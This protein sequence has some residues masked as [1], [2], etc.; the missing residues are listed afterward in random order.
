MPN[1]QLC[2]AVT[3]RTMS[4]IRRNRDAATGADI[5][6][7]RLDTVDR[8]DVAGALEGRRCPVIV[9]C[10]AAW[11]NGFFQGAE[12]ERRRI[13]EEA[14]ALGAEFVDVEAKAG[15]AGEL[16]AARGGRGV[17]V[18]SHVYGE[19]PSDLA[20]RWE[21]LTGS[22]AEIAKLAVEARSLADTAKVMALGRPAKDDGRGYVLIAMGDQGLAS[23]VLS[24]RT[25]NRWTYAGD[26][27]APGQVSAQRMLD[28]FRFRDLRPGTAVYGVV[29]NPVM[30]SLSPVMHNAGF[31]HFG[32][33]AV[34]LPLLATDAADFVEFARAIGLSGA[35]ITAPFKVQLMEA[36][37]ELEPLAE[38]VGAINT[39]I[40]RDGKWKGANTDVYGFAAP[41]LAK[42]QN[43]PASAGRTNPASAGRLAAGLRTTI[44]GAGGA[45]RAVAVALADLGAAVT[46]CARRPEAAREV[47]ALAD[48]QIGGLP[49]PAGSWDVLI[50]STS[51]DGDMS[52]NSPVPPATLDGRLVYELLYVPPVTR[53]MA[54]AAAAGCITIGGLE[55]LVA[56]AEKQFE[57]W[58]GQTPPAGLFQ[59]AAAQSQS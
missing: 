6:E 51:W 7:M 57:L 16:V 11:E 27:V 29:G 12:E 45:A 8:P 58:T 48:G 37:D 26:N 17:V 10:R 22:G 50:N 28:E 21:A 39:L 52:A 33:D 15:F 34:Y 55:M 2:V 59:K 24:T 44:L 54:D 36:V 32:I 5:V 23:R 46:V 56:Q 3:G 1:S 49:P 19:C 47:A 42:L 41:L 14:V 53:L 40:M 38:R 35:S 4:E 13:L 9:T 43:L 20:A 18:S 25:G 30:H 31:R